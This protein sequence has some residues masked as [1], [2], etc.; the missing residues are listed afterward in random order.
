M[1]GLSWCITR[2]HTQLFRRPH[3]HTPQQTRTCGFDPAAPAAASPFFSAGWS[4]LVTR[5]WC[6]WA[7]LFC[8]LFCLLS[9]VFVF[10]FVFVRICVVCGPHTQKVHTHQHTC[11]PTARAPPPCPPSPSYPPPPAASPSPG[12]GPAFCGC[13]PPALPLG[14]AAPG[15][16]RA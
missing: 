5:K 13:P 16:R 4:F 9:V 15:R 8:V 12:P 11:N 3:I 2:T 7:E 10:V 1:L 6:W 14:R